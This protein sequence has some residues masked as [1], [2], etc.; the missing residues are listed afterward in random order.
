MNLL[1]QPVLAVT[2]VEILF[3]IVAFAGFIIWIIVQVSKAAPKPG[4]GVPGAPQ[5]AGRKPQG[6]LQKEIDIFLRQVSPQGANRRTADGD[7]PQTAA[8]RRTPPPDRPGGSRSG[9]GKREQPPSSGDRGA[10]PGTKIADRKGPGRKDLGQDVRQH[11]TE[12]LD[13][14][15]I[16]GRI[17]QDLQNRVQQSVDSHLGP[18]S[19]KLGPS[20]ASPTQTTA[21]SQAVSDA[22]LSDAAQF[23]RL[24][25]Q[26]AEIRQAILLNEVLSRPIALRKSQDS[27]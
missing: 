3:G 18:A 20:A 24:L 1:P 16:G 22:A 17:D 25:R 10:K 27:R 19:A 6:S 14:R 5:P 7:V 26:P 2:C 21:G 15:S 11:V 12:H 23:R 4:P 13:S 9:A 8:P